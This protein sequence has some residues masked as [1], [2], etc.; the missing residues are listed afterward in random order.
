MR[1]EESIAHEETYK[2]YT[3][4]LIHDQ[5]PESPRTWSNVGT[6]VCW[7]SRHTLGDEQPNCSH[8]E[9][10]ENLT[11]K[12]IDDTSVRVDRIRDWFKYDSPYINKAERVLS[13]AH[14]GAIRKNFIILP[15]YLYDHSGII[16]S[17]GSFSCPWDSGQVGF[18]YCTLEKALEEWGGTDEEARSKATAYMESE[19]KTYSSYLEGDVVGWAVEDPDGEDVESVWGYYPDDSKGYANRWEDPINEAKHSIDH[20]IEKTN[21]L[22]TQL[23]ANI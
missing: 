8:E 19:V 12:L 17:T 10:L 16:M 14:E 7:H 15:L 21:E 1:F 18:I 5:D 2:G 3:I 13:K 22:D 11:S 9:Y 4:K 6:M 23:C 20:H